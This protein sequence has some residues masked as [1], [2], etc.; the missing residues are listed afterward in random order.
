MTIPSDET[1]AGLT[2]ERFQELPKLIRSA[3]TSGIVHNADW[4]FQSTESARGQGAGVFPG[5]Q[6]TGAVP[7]DSKRRRQT[8][9]VML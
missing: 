5:R 9:C 4:S 2:S 6:A 7:A 8:T 1:M 3:A